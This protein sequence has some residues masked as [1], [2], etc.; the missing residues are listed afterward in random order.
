[1]STFELVRNMLCSVIPV[2][3]LHDCSPSLVETEH[4]P[5]LG[6]GAVLLLVG[7]SRR[8][9]LGTC[10]GVASAPLLYRGLTG[11]SPDV[12]NGSQPDRTK[13][14]LRVER[15]VHVRESL[16]L[17]VPVGDV[18]PFWRCLHCKPPGTSDALLTACRLTR[19]CPTDNAIR[20]ST[21]TDAS[22]RTDAFVAPIAKHR[23]FARIRCACEP[24]GDRRNHHHEERRD[25]GGRHAPRRIH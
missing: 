17:E 23:H 19:R 8:S 11:R 15:G 13:T 24:R 9:V 10:L 14:A 2:D 6:V 5:A 1:M 21:T 16:R 3:A 4:C 20:V 22:T 18:Y 7:A 12:L 25:V